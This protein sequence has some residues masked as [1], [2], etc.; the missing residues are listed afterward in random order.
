MFADIAS[1]VITEESDISYIL[2]TESDYNMKALAEQ[3]HL[4]G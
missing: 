2:L 3:S 1:S 4:I